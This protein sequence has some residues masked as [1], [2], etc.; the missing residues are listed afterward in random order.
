MLHRG[1]SVPLA[2]LALAVGTQAT[3]LAQ[4]AQQPALQSALEPGYGRLVTFDALTAGE[5][6][7]I[8]SFTDL[9]N[10]VRVRGVRL[11]APNSACVVE[12]VTIT[13]TN[14]QV[15][16]ETRTIDLRAGERTAVIDPRFDDR[17]LE[18][19]IV[20]VRP[21]SCSG[22][23][24]ELQGVIDVA[25]SNSYASRS[26]KAPTRGIDPAGS[27]QPP[28]APALP[29]APAPGTLPDL[30]YTAV[31]LYYG[32][33]RKA[34]EPR[35]RGDQVRIGTYGAEPG[36]RLELGKATVS[37]PKNRKPGT[38]PVAG[39]DL[40]ITT[41]NYRQADL[42]RDFTVLGVNAISQDKFVAAIQARLGQAQSYQG[43]AFVFI[44]GYFVTFDDAIF[45]AAQITYDMGFDGLPL[46]YSWPSAGQ[47]RQYITDRDRAREA[48]DYLKDF[49]NLVAARSGATQI[50]LIA[51]STGAHALLEAL[52]RMLLQQPDLAGTGRFGE[53]VFAAPD[54]LAGDFQNAMASLVKLARG[55][56]LYASKSDRAL[57]LSEFARNGAQAAGLVPANG[58][59]VLVA[60]V[61]SIDVSLLNT[62]YFGINHSS[63]GDAQPLLQDLGKVFATGYHPPSSRDQSFR[64]TPAPQNAGRFWRWMR[65]P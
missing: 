53:I 42:A 9:R 6:G 62:S 14:G 19:V 64:E 43:H 40:V 23:V 4:Q 16:N 65:Q 29:K 24:L 26:A 47:F 34:G 3:S 55:T 13:Y 46:V 39:V 56:T 28:A 32:T 36:G 50:H 54:V 58:I 8:I 61:D 5:A 21:G 10:K 41:L 17:S 7:Q 35:T 59:P 22:A 27:S 63:F 15:H 18:S 51:H 49:L 20:A 30:P 45:R 48:R 25:A 52:D 31:D 60:G 33:D 38:I 2:L 37:I 12:N 44:H 11:V 1:L 57:Q